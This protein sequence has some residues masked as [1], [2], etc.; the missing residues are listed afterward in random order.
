M[1]FPEPLLL[2]QFGQSQPSLLLRLL[3]DLLLHPPP[4]LLDLPSLLS[5]ATLLFSSPLSLFLLGL[6]C[7]ALT[8]A[9]SQ[10]TK[11]LLHEV[12]E[13]QRLCQAL[14]SPSAGLLHQHQR[15]AH[16]AEPPAEPAPRRQCPQSQ[17]LP[18]R[19]Q[20]GLHPSHQQGP[21]GQDPRGFRPPQLREEPWQVEAQLHGV[22]GPHPALPDDL[23]HDLP[24]LLRVRLNT[25]GAHVL[26]SLEL[27]SLQEEPRHAQGPLLRVDVIGQH[28]GLDE[29]AVPV[30]LEALGQE[31]PEARDD[32]IE[33]AA[34]GIAVVHDLHQLNGT[35]LDDLIQ[36][37]LVL[38]EAGLL[39]LVRLEATDVM[40]MA[41]VESLQQAFEICTVLLAD[42]PEWHLGLVLIT[43]RLHEVKAG[44]A[45]Q[46]FTFHKQPIVILV[47]P[48]LGV[49]LYRAGVVLHDEALV[50]S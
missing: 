34:V 50:Q 32:L 35:T 44:I 41:G 17:L 5:D 12:E 19:Q 25:F 22:L 43:Q 31:V 6:L 28:Q 48:A 37:Q 3:P 16:R 27:P 1:L 38:E 39:L 7:S 45:N 15:E 49:V 47:Q 18:G 11:P 13:M 8:G 10:R 33:R 30:A 21:G 42:G 20:H 9:V 36:D 23:P 14:P 40:Q 24:Q 29:G 2:F 4:L 46:L 26:E